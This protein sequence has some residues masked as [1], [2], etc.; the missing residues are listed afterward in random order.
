MIVARKDNEAVAHAMSLRTSAQK[1]NLLASGIRNKPVDFALNWLHFSHRRIAI[2]VHKTLLSA[3]ANAEHNHGLNIDNLYVKEAFVG[4]G[5]RMKRFHARG[6]GR[7]AKIIKPFSH[8]TIW[9]AEYDEE[10]I[11][12]KVKVIKSKK[13]SQKATKKTSGDA[14]KAEK[15]NKATT[16]EKTEMKADNSKDT[17]STEKSIDASKSDSST[18]SK[19]K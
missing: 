7:G 1:L 11:E 16:T 9:V 14:Y 6:R 13:D 2:Q 17:K 12:E 18:D 8:L 15:R 5:V 3:I 4:Q 19:D 10:Q